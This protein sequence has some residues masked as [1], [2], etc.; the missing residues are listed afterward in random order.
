VAALLLT[1][2]STPV[3]A[4]T[5]DAAVGLYRVTIF[6]PESNGAIDPSTEDWREDMETEVVDQVLD[7]CLYWASMAPDWAE[8]TCDVGYYHFVDTP[9]GY[10]PII[11]DGGAPLLGFWGGEED[12]W[13]NEI[14]DVMGFAS[15]WLFYYQEVE[16]YNDW[17]QEEY[18]AEEAFSVFVVNSENDDDG[19][20]AND[21]SAYV[22]EIRAPYLVMT[23]DNG[24]WRSLLGPTSLQTTAA[25]EMG[26]VFGAEDE[27]HG[28]NSSCSD[29]SSG[30]SNDNHEDCPGGARTPC[31]MRQD[32]PC[33]YLPP[34]PLCYWTRGQVGWTPECPPIGRCDRLGPWPCQSGSQ[35]VDESWLC[36]GEADCDDRSD[37]YGCG[38]CAS[39]EYFCPDGGC[40]RTYEMCLCPDADDDDARDETCGGEDCDDSTASVSP[41]ADET[42]N[43]EDDDCDGEVDEGFDRDRDGSSTCNHPPDCDDGDASRYPGAP[44]VCG[45]G[46]DQDCSGSD[47]QCG[48]TDADGDGHGSPE[49]GGDD[50]DDHDPAVGGGW[51]SCGDNP[52]CDGGTCDG[53][54]ADADVVSEPEGG[55]GCTAAGRRAIDTDAVFRRVITAPRR[56]PW[57]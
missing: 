10:E 39:Y 55:C 56:Y 14:M 9:T 52:P 22:P 25:H 35:C 5:P 27:Y 17:A 19:S 18:G 54:P 4:N 33:G 3:R 26:H 51:P 50:C 49:C 8:L 29:E 42:C 38:G 46:I 30:Y 41:A 32:A 7:A 48:C 47:Q 45:D 40:E 12:D 21:M 23:W 44:D 16:D 6:L 53:G 24:G 13:I 57:S 37:E 31:L 28:S 15:M 43:D 2:Q 1:V 34:N 20:F 11:H 36:D